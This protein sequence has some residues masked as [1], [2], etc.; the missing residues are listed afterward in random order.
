MKGRL[1]EPAHGLI[2][3]SNLQVHLDATERMQALDGVLDKRGR[4]PALAM[5]GR[6]REVIKPAPHAVVAGHYRALI[7]GCEGSHPKH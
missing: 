4:Y 6:H 7:F 3:A 2:P 1:V 5:R